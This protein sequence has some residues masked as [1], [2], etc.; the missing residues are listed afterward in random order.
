M[1]SKDS[2]RRSQKITIAA[3]SSMVRAVG[4]RR[5]WSRAL[6]FKLRS[7]ARRGY[8]VKRRCFSVKKR[9]VTKKASSGELKQAEKLRSLVPGGEAME[10]CELLEET[11]DY[12]KCL[13][14]QVI[15]AYGKHQKGSR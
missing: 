2:H 15:R 6:L 8:V 5:A 3:Y 11:A 13:A 4:T 12:I 7:Q 10:F 14:T 9:R 1:S